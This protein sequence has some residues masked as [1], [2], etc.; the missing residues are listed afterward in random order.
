MKK[1]SHE[2]AFNALLAEQAPSVTQAFMS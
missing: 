1:L 2:K